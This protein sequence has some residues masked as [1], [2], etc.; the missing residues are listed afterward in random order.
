MGSKSRRPTPKIVEG[1]IAKKFGQGKGGDYKPWMYSRDFANHAPSFH[2]ASAVTGRTHFY[3][4]NIELGCHY[5]AEYSGKLRDIREQYALL[6]WRELQVVAAKVGIPY[7][8]FPGTTTWVFSTDLV[9]EVVR[10]DGFETIAVCVKPAEE[11]SDPNVL[12]KLWLEKFYWRRR[13]IKWILYCGE[14]NLHQNLRF[15][16]S[17]IRHIGQIESIGVPT[18]QFAKT[19]EKHW[20]PHLSL[21]EVNFSA[22]R[23]IGMREQDAMHLLAAAVWRRQINIDLVSEPLSHVSPVK[24]IR[25]QN[26]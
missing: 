19:F 18:A 26:G 16:D 1:W 6:P 25:N 14:D 13:N 20:Q 7:P 4:S 3:F 12:A 15:F 22:A 17:G 11:L 23:E 10:K 9:L 5:V 8:M 2:V 24:L 21:N